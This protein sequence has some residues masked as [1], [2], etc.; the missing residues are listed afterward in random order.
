M[1]IKLGSY[2]SSEDTGSG[3]MAGWTGEPMNQTAC[4]VRGGCL[5]SITGV[6][7]KFAMN[8]LGLVCVHVREKSDVEVAR[9]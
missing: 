9:G 4:T 6:W 3:A 1:A 2:S 8:G 7:S 5:G